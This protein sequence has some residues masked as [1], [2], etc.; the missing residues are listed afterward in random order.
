MARSFTLHGQ[1]LCLQGLHQ[2][3]GPS[4]ECRPCLPFD[5]LGQ[6]FQC[7]DPILIIK[8][9]SV[10]SVGDK[11]QHFVATI[12]SIGDSDRHSKGS[13]TQ[14]HHGSPVTLGLGVTGCSSNLT[15]LR[16]HP[17]SCRV[18]FK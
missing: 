9:S 7:C 6:E 1:H 13:C 14:R 4:T 12:S 18:P 17:V 11:N 2:Q 8:K 15:F 10:S 3:R 16:T 5:S